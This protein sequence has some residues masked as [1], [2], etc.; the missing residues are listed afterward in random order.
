MSTTFF[1]FIQNYVIINFSVQF[2]LT[3]TEKLKLHNN[4]V[5]SNELEIY[6]LHY[7]LNQ[8]DCKVSM[9]GF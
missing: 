2:G 9:L 7:A 4:C 5:Q 1:D 6:V 8:A 3:T